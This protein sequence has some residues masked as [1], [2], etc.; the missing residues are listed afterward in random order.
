MPSTFLLHFQENMLF[1]KI[2]WIYALLIWASV[3]ATYDLLD[4]C[5]PEMTNAC[6]EFCSSF[7]PQERLCYAQRAGSLCRH[8]CPRYV[9]EFCSLLFKGM[10]RC[11]DDT[12]YC[13]CNAT[14][15]R[16]SGC[17]TIRKFGAI[18]C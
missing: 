13:G 2:F 1:K 5:T 16:V 17:R 10:F 8:D 7:D 14:P 15:N 6:D 9:R 12:I 3:I 4:D 11:Q 18:S